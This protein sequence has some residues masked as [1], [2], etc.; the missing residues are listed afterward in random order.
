LQN[1]RFHPRNDV[2]FIRNYFQMDNIDVEASSPKDDEASIRNYFQM[3]NIAAEASSPEDDEASIGYSNFQMEDAVDVKKVD[4]E[5]SATDRDIDSESECA[6]DDDELDVLLPSSSTTHELWKAWQ[7]PRASQSKSGCNE[8]WEAR[9][10][11][12]LRGLRSP[13]FVPTWDA[14]A[15]SA[16]LSAVNLWSLL[17]MHSEA[18]HKTEIADDVEEWEVYADM[19]DDDLWNTLANKGQHGTGQKSE[20]IVKA[21]QSCA[22]APLAAP[23]LPAAS[24]MCKADSPRKHLSKHTK[25]QQKPKTL[26]VDKPSKP[27]V[28]EKQPRAESEYRFQGKIKARELNKTKRSMKMNYGFIEINPKD[29]KALHEHPLWTSDLEVDVF[30]H[31]KD[32]DYDTQYAGDIV[33][34]SV[35]LKPQGGCLQAQK[36]SLKK[37]SEWWHSVSL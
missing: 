36:L 4:A 10:A 7:S 25:L 6:E 29:L 12:Y 32:C 14:D 33:T 31:C 15:P 20:V 37:R 18:D 1:K 19:S 28:V 16:D 21:S 22:G 24:Q 34:F 2:A 30:W 3:D 35:M 11:A 27:A 26:V 23:V 9:R 13:A 5:D 8:E 17:E